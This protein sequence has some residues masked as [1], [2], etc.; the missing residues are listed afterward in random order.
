MDSALPDRQVVDQIL[1]ATGIVFA[2][3]I[4]RVNTGG[5]KPEV[6]MAN[7]T[8]LLFL[9]LIIVLT[10]IMHYILAWKGPRPDDKS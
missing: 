3:I 9:V 5:L 1:I 6:V 4:T 2:H 8:E 7:E 10:M